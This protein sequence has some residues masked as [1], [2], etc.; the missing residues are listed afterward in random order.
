MSTSPI[1]R[2]AMKAYRLLKQKAAK[3]KIPPVKVTAER[4]CKIDID[5]SLVRTEKSANT[6]FERTK[7]LD[8]LNSQHA[9]DA[10]TKGM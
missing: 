2:K 4:S 7:I 3:Q 1:A 5:N 8:M 10:I 6:N 9:R